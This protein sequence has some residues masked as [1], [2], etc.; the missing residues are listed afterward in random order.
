MKN[1]CLRVFS[2]LFFAGVVSWAWRAA[3]PALTRGPYLQSATETG[4]T[5]VCQTASST[6]LVLRYGTRSGPPWD[7]EASSP[8]GT[9][10]VI[11]LGALRPSTRYYY[12]LAAGSSVLAGGKEHYFRTSPAEKSRASFRFL[13]WG[14]SGTGSSTQFDVAA[15]MEEV[16]PHPEFALGLGDLVYDSGA[17]SDYDPKLFE[18]YAGIFPRMTFWPTLGNHDVKTSNGAP[19]LDA[20]YLPT[21]TGAPG[22]PSNTERYYSFDH[23]MAHFVCADSE[24]SSS[25]P[26]SAMYEWLADDLDDA[27]AR[28]KRWLFAFLHH[29]PYSKGTHDSDDEGDLIAVRENLVP[30]FE[31]KGV[32]M[33][34]VG[35]SHN[36]ERS[37][38]ARN[39]AILQNHPNDYTKIG[40]PNGTI[41]LVSGCG[42]KTGSGSLD[43]PLMAT[44]YGSVAGFNVIDV[45]H[46]ELRGYFVERDGET[47]DLFAVHKAADVVPPRVTAVRPH[48]ASE[49]EVVFSEPVQAGGAENVASYQLS[50]GASVLDAILGSDQHT[51]MLSTSSLQANRGYQ[52]GLSGIS[53]GV[54]NDIEQDASFVLEGQGSPGGSDGGVPQGANWRYWK[55]SAVPPSGWAGRTFADS[56]WSQGRAG[57]GFEDGDDQTVL[58]DMKDSYLTVYIRTAFEVEDPANVTAMQLGVLY[59]DGFVAFL[60]G[61]EVARANV[62]AGQTNTTPASASHEAAGFEPFDLDSVRG[63]LVAGTNVLAVQG[64]NASLAS[65]DFSLHPELLLTIDGGGGGGGGG[66][67]VAVLD[68]DVQTANAPATIAFSSTRSRDGD[69]PLASVRWD[70]GDGS[71]IATGTNAQHVYGQDGVYVASLLVTD[72]DGMEGLDQREIRIHS[73]GNGPT[74]ALSASDQEVDA[75]QSVSFGSSGSRDPDGGAV[76][77]SW[78]FGDPASGAENLS[79]NASPSHVFASDGTYTVVLTVTDDEGSED[80]TSTVITVG[81]GSV[82]APNAAFAVVASADPLRFDFT[83]QSTGDVTSWLWDFDDGSTSVLQNPSHTYAGAGHYLVSLTVEGPGGSDSV[84]QE[85]QIGQVAASFDHA[86]SPTDDHE[87]YFTDQSTG[88]ITSWAWDFGDGASSDIQNPIHAYADEGDYTVVLTVSGPDGNDADQQV[89]HIGDGSGGG[90]SGGGCAAVIDEGLGNRGDPSLAS[91]LAL[92]LLIALARSA[93]GARRTVPLAG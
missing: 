71:P 5:V 4:I 45:S 65:S 59:D 80:A 55:G 75:G 93:R 27:R 64:H 30:M 35:H 9:T 49:V 60:N 76:L 11:R 12:E 70:F 10:H 89:I 86:L 22:H 43:H 81:S 67:P 21:D 69:G 54:G 82:G 61:T 87:V 14:D 2:I 44:S 39:D 78:N 25:D 63:L 6:T 26:G 72:A 66:P 28:G 50:G 90:G 77:T 34:M 1:R 83:D 57:F 29:P 33:V 51:A 41:Y 40:S 7:G 48:S 15:R 23:G 85:I 32:D 13:A 52:L 16:L 3:P 74:A 47:T 88:N 84:T 18:P 46:D 31:S 36:Y 20:F 53:D 42:G 73:V 79:G 8:S 91:L 17:A 38:L 37:Y 58:S 92:V 68:C 62:P 24:S 19:Y 56:A